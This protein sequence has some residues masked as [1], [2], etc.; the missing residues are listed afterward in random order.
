MLARYAEDSYRLTSELA[1]VLKSGGQ[2][3]MIVGNSCLKGTFIRNSDGVRS[4][5]AM[6]GLSL[7]EETE[8]E[9]PEN[10]RYLPIPA[11]G[12]GSLAKRMRTETILTFWKQ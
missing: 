10:S 4:A 8:R 5:A 7:H 9:L 12:E 3:I 1:R 11:A 2:A 6:V